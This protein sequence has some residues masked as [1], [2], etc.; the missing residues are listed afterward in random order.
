MDLGRLLCQNW[1]PDGIRKVG[2][3]RTRWDQRICDFVET[4]VELDLESWMTLAQDREA[5]KALEEEFAQ[6]EG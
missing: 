2:R 4:Y 5:W 3:L 1:A 6:L